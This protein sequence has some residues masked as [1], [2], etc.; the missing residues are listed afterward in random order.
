MHIASVIRL[1]PVSFVFCMQNIAFS[2]CKS[3]MYYTTTDSIHDDIVQ[4]LQLDGVEVQWAYSYSIS[5][6]FMWALFASERSKRFSGDLGLF[7]VFITPAKE[8]K[9]D[10]NC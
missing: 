9:T 7:S 6:C 4:R 5:M 8:K 10:I 1:H 2:N 3:S